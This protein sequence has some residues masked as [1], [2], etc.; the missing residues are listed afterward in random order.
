MFPY[1]AGDMFTGLPSLSVIM[2]ASSGLSCVVPLAYVI[3]IFPPARS[4]ASP[5]LYCDFVG[6]VI[7]IFVILSFTLY[8][9]VVVFV[10]PSSVY[11]TVAVFPVPAVV[12]VNPLT[13]ESC[14]F[15]VSVF[16]AFLVTFNVPP[17]PVVESFKLYCVFGDVT[18]VIWSIGFFIV[19]V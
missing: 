10:T 11:V 17:T 9:Y 12:V 16:P 2:L 14:I 19:I 4:N 6:G 7:A 13:I 8:V 1:D 15:T 3:V 18:I 5:W